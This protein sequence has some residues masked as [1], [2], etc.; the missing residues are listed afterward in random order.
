[1]AGTGATGICGAVGAVAGRVYD[2]VSKDDWLVEA[3]VVLVYLPL[4]VALGEAVLGCEAANDDALGA[5]AASIAARDLKP[6]A[7]GHSP[8]G[9]RFL[10]DL[11]LSPREEGKGR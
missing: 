7:L 6:P 2:A 11:Y 3:P 1:M 9:W 10:R 8:V 4:L 5:E